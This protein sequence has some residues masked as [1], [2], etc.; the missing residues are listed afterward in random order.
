MLVNFLPIDADSV[1]DGTF[2]SSCGKGS[3]DIADADESIPVAGREDAGGRTQEWV[4]NLTTTTDPEPIWKP[5]RNGTYT[6]RKYLYME[7]IGRSV[8]NV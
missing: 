3:S 4:D 1:S 5:S 6:G 8:T 7:A 2:V